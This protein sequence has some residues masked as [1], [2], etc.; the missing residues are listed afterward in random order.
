M[1]LKLQDSKTSISNKFIDTYFKKA[2]YIYCMVYI[3][4][5]RILSEREKITN[6]A[7]ANTL[8]LPISDVINAW[9]Y[10]SAEGIVTYTE[11]P[12]SV[13]LKDEF[14]ILSSKKEQKKVITEKRPEYSPAEID[15]FSRNNENIKNLFSTAQSHLGKMLT[16][17]DLSIILGLY[18]WLRLPLDVIEILFAYCTKNNHYSLRYI[19]AV[20]LDWAEKEINTPKKAIEYIR[21][22]NKEYRTIMKSM[23]I[24]NRIPTTAEEKFMQRWLFDYNMNM[25]IICLACERTVLATGKAGFP[26][27]DTIITDWHN[28]NVK[29]KEDVEKIDRSFLQSKKENK[30]KAPVVSSQPI[31]K[32]NRFVNY[33]QRKWDF[34]K[35]RSL[36]RQHIK[37]QLQNDD[38]GK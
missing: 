6:E 32:K 5:C 17:N 27:A 1:S 24:T 30:T 33:E 4:A 2:P 25:D 20:A 11:N 14:F 21:L 35:L 16:H 36:E 22:H 34:E 28:K 38:E 18:D 15:I 26:Y 13:S 12:F 23:G 9:K 29:T 31:Q 3:Y 7:I 19:E 10:F 8:R 37:K